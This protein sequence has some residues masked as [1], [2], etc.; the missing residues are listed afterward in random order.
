MTK[1]V[2]REEGGG[3]GERDRQTDREREREGKIS[4]KLV[5]ESIIVEDGSTCGSTLVY[6]RL[7]CFL[8]LYM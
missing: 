7:W 2:E 6:W 1:Y 4:I 5:C 8:A 3:G